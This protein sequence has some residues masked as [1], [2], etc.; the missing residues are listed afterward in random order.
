[1][2]RSYYRVSIQVLIPVHCTMVYL[3]LLL[4]AVLTLVHAYA[5]D[6][7]NGLFGGVAMVDLAVPADSHTQQFCPCTST[8]TLYNDIPCNILVLCLYTYQC[9][10]VKR[11]MS[12]SPHNLRRRSCHFDVYTSTE[13]SV[14]RASI[15]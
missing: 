14:C 5:S 3:I 2:F 4:E 12:L 1:M 13:Y 15:P 11:Y 9:N 8:I 7:P 6:H 10:S